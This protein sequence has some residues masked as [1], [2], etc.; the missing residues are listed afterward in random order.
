[1]AFDQVPF[2]PVSFG[3]FYVRSLSL[4]VT[5]DILPAV[6]WR[7]SAQ[8]SQHFSGVSLLKSKRYVQE[9]GGGDLQITSLLSTSLFPEPS[10]LS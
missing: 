8:F 7:A 9:M 1:V 3:A 4:S 5:D 10:D 6:H 2:G